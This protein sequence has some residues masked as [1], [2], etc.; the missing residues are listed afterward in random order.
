M[1]VPPL[2][3][4]APEHHG[5]LAVLMLPV[6]AGDIEAGQ[7]A[8]APFRALATP[9]ADLVMPMPYPGIYQFTEGAAQPGLEVTRSLFFD[10]L[11]DAAVDLIIERLETAPSAMAAGQLRVLGGA[12]ARVPADATAFAH[13]TARGLFTLIT[14]YEDVADTE[15]QAAWT[16]SFAAELARLSTGVYSNFIA[17][18]GE[19][20]VHDAYPGATYERL[21]AVKRRYDPSNLFRLNQNIRPDA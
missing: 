5:R 17:D 10:D 18:E 6:Y 7:R 12:M 20:R 8:L 9:I 1:R 19:A 21:V 16:D 3:F 14:M 2:P 11:D 15:R 13:R 4:V